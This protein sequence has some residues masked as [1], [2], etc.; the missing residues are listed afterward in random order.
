MP[1]TTNRGLGVK[2]RQRGRGIAHRGHLKARTPQGEGKY[3][4]EFPIIVDEEDSF[5]LYATPQCL[6]PVHWGT[7]PHAPAQAGSEVSIWRIEPRWTAGSLATDEAAFHARRRHDGHR[8]ELESRAVCQTITR[9]GAPVPYRRS[10]P[11]ACV[12]PCA[13]GWDRSVSHPWRAG[14]SAASREGS[15]ARGRVTTSL[16]AGSGPDLLQA[17]D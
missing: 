11:V 13:I 14:C 1:S 10:Q 15:G 5:V 17:R 9:Y 4:N 7:P 2:Q 12:P 3:G 8:C 16:R 6:H